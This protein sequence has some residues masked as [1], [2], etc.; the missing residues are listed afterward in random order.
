[1]DI[2]NYKI[3][4][5]NKIRYNNKIRC[6]N[7][8][9]SIAAIIILSFIVWDI[10]GNLNEHNDY[11]I[12]MYKEVS[13]IR[14]LVKN[15]SPYFEE[16]TL[17]TIN[18]IAN[19]SIPLEDQLPNELTEKEKSRILKEYYNSKTEGLRK[20]KIFLAQETITQE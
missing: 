5:N 13:A 14:E 16:E 2:Q 7:Y 17:N 8:L 4:F 12:E 11:K 15:S 10:Y 3:R 6:F 18:E 19:D 1:M 20:I 9:I